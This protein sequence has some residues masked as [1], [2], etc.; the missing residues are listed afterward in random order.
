[1]GRD[2]PMLKKVVPNGNVLKGLRTEIYDGKTTFCRQIGTYPLVVGVK[3]RL[4]LD[5]LIDVKVVG[6]QLRSVVGEKI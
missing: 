2:N 6:H 5:K 4:G 1:M 3:G